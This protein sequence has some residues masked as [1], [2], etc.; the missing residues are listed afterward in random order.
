MNSRQL[1]GGIFVI[2]AAIFW[3]VTGILCQLLTQNNNISPIWMSA[4]RAF[5]AG[6]ILVAYCAI[7]DRKRLFSIFKE[8]DGI[9]G[10]IVLTVF[11]STTVQLTFMC[12]VKYS[13]AATAT[14]LQYVSPAIVILMMFVV[15]HQRPAI[16]E[17][18]CTILA[19]AGVFF[20]ATHGNVSSLAISVQ[21]LIWGLSSAVELAFYTIYPTKLIKKYGIYVVSA[22]SMFLSGCVLCLVTKP[23]NCEGTIDAVTISAM[24]YMIVF[25]T[26][27]A[28]SIYSI[29]VTYIGE[30]KANILATIEPLAAFVLSVVFMHVRF[31]LYDCVGFVCI[32]MIT[33]LLAKEGKNNE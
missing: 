21:A 19:I 11:G 32:L 25:A 1:K 5:F 15:K 6:L 14:I 7:K 26:V 8:K 2:A 33:F 4:M 24:V 17:V 13:N 9:I 12:A 27:I 29:G 3:A 23:W 28:F 30:T 20:I 31:T 18:I 16:K 10:V 22:W